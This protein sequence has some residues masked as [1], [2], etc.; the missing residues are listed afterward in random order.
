MPKMNGLKVLE[1]LKNNPRTKHIPIIIY[2]TSS[3][4]SDIE[5]A[6]AKG[7]NSY[8]VK[9][10]KFEDLVTLM[11]SIDDYWIKQVKLP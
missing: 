3:L 8:L 1:R 4:E 9:P 2:S 5:N 7:A 10:V 6:Y 11:V